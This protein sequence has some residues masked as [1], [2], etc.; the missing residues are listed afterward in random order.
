MHGKFNA[1]ILLFEA[2]DQSVKVG[3]FY[4]LSG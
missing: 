4:V 1:E 2:R 3:G